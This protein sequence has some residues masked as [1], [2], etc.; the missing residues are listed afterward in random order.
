M[1]RTKAAVLRDLYAEQ[2]RLASLER[3][4]ENTPNV[5]TAELSDKLIPSVKRKIAELEA[6]LETAPEDLPLNHESWRGTAPPKFPECCCNFNLPA[7]VPGTP[8]W[9]ALE[10]PSVL[11]RGNPER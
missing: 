9:E 6:E 8:E 11:R 10:I 7:P 1:T 3:T 4:A 2:N 5:K